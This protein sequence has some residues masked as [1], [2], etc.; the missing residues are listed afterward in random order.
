LSTYGG[1]LEITETM[2]KISCTYRHALLFFLS[3]FSLSLSLSWSISTC[4]L[5]LLLLK[6]FIDGYAY[7]Y[8]SIL[9]IVRSLARSMK[10]KVLLCV[11]TTN[12]KNISI[13]ICFLL[14]IVHRTHQLRKR[15]KKINASFIYLSL[16]FFIIQIRD[17]QE[18]IV[19]KQIIS[20]YKC[21][22]R[23]KRNEILKYVIRRK[24]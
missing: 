23:I 18:D 12:K 22:I 20:N 14:L 16:F 13:E 21:L 8:T 19:D 3:S 11:H 9:S 15:E 4:W 2:S 17:F 5:L 7:A 1:V 24:K 10:I 6:T